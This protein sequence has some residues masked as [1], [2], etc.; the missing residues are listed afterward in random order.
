[1]EYY[2]NYKQAENERSESVPISNSSKTHKGS[3]ESPFGSKIENS[4]KSIEDFTSLIDGRM[5]LREEN[6]SSIEDD[7]CKADSILLNLGKWFPY[8][9][10]S[11]EK[12]RDALD[13]ELFRLERQKRDEH[14]KCW[15]D[16]IKLR[17][18]LEDVIRQ[19]D[20]QKKLIGFWD[21]GMC[22]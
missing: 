11:V 1:M 3:P 12:K 8:L 16:T 13:M 9:N 22:E 18:Q 17:E 10:K 21:G 15:K 19:Y 2:T 7:I 20:G 5:K 4:K 14:T 6:L